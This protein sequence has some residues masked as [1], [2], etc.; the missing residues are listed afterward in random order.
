M[1]NALMAGILDDSDDSDDGPSA[2]PMETE[3]APKPLVCGACK[4]PILGADGKPRYD[5]ECGGHCC[6]QCKQPVHSRIICDQVW[7]PVELRFFC[8]KA[9]LLS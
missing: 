5:G 3:A 4:E 1:V 9:C 8:S 7:E 2:A 6:I